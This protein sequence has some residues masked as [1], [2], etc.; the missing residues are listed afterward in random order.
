MRYKLGML[1]STATMATNKPATLRTKRFMRAFGASL[2]CIVPERGGVQGD[3][4]ARLSKRA[5]LPC[6]SAPPQVNGCE[7]ILAQ[8]GVYA[9][10]AQ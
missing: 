5:G 8:T 7:A 10:V 6:W 1:N 9:P 2:A 3:G 4:K